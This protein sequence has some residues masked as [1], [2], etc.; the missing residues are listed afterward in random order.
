MLASLEI[1]G[2]EHSPIF[3]GPHFF[4][5]NLKDESMVLGFNFASLNFNN[6][7]LPY[8]QTY[9]SLSPSL[10][11]MVHSNLFHDTNSLGFLTGRTFL[12]TNGHEWFNNNINGLKITT[13]I[14]ENVPVEGFQNTQY[15][16]LN[17]ITKD[18]QNLLRV[19][20]FFGKQLSKSKLI[21]ENSE[22]KL[23]STLEFKEDEYIAHSG[24]GVCG[25]E[26]A[27]ESHTRLG[28]SVSKGVERQK[29]DME[30]V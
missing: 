20:K 24:A 3:C 7:S 23:A 19:P 1:S 25:E 6:L 21:I 17:V 29:Y 16:K 22:P 12:S 15:G 18:K 5:H 13:K 10:M 26:D 30:Q 9:L 14:K 28:T 11:L 2:L 8:S 4:R 27:R